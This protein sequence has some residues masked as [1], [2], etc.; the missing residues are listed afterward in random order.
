QEKPC[1]QQCSSPILRQDQCRGARTP[2]LG[3]LRPIRRRPWRPKCYSHKEDR[4]RVRHSFVATPDPPSTRAA[5]GPWALWA[6]TQS[7]TT[8]Q[9][10]DREAPSDGSTA[11]AKRDA[12]NR[13]AAAEQKR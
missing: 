9:N 12:S 8:T 2:R 4:R 5:S 11:L 3:K 1:M 6:P 10:A 13:P 7:K